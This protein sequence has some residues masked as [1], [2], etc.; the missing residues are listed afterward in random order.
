MTDIEDNNVSGNKIYD[1]GYVIH[2]KTFNNDVSYL[3]GMDNLRLTCDDEY[4]EK[5]PGDSDEHTF[6]DIAFEVI[7]G[8]QLATQGVMWSVSNSQKTGRT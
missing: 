6:S 4:E 5:L 1:I 2:Y 3:W 7:Q 8:V